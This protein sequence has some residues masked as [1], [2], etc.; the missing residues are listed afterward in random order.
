MGETVLTFYAEDL[1]YIHAAGFGGMAAAAAPEV[2][3]LLRD[4]GIATGTIGDI[5]CGCGVSTRCFLDAGY[6]VWALEPSRPLLELARAAAP[7][8]EFLPPAS[9]YDAELPAADALVALGEPLTYHTAG[10][11]ADKHVFAFFSRAASVL[12]PGGILVFD[13]IVRGEPSL[14]ARPWRAGEDWA[15]LVETHEDPSSGWL[16][17]EIE[18]FR[19]N[20][21]GAG[22]SR[23][24]RPCRKPAP[25]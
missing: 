5:G 12:R 17:R 20:V 13:V 1:A 18:T 22:E 3:A 23:H 14:D 21:A 11:D 15:V 4:G 24:N 8:A 6:A 25:L 16:R 19:M 2:V 7:G 9:V 10:S